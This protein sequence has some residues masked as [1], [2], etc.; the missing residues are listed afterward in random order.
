MCE[1]LITLNKKYSDNLR[2]WIHDIVT[3]QNISLPNVT[4]DMKS[5]FF[6]RV[7][8][9]LYYPN[10]KIKKIDNTSK[11]NLLHYFSEKRVTKKP[12]KTQSENFHL[13]VEG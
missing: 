6:K 5:S 1:V 9:L 11:K 8:R 12:C 7:L 3:V 2:R 13:S 10:F 4:E